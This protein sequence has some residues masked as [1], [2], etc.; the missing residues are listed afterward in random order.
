MSEKSSRTSAKR[1]GIIAVVCSAFLTG[2]SM[3]DIAPTVLA[4][5]SVQLGVEDVIAKSTAHITWFDGVQIK[6]ADIVVS[7]CIAQSQLPDGIDTSIIPTT[8]VSQTK[9][10]TITSDDDLS[11]LYDIEVLSTDKE[12]IINVGTV[13]DGA[14]YRLEDGWYGF[15][16]PN[17][18]TDEFYIRIGNAYFTER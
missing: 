2:C 7:S 1:F 18:Y 8:D 3:N 12:K 11:G 5:T 6:E 10:F 9:Y 16:L 14:V 17:G 13:Y 15:V 4:G